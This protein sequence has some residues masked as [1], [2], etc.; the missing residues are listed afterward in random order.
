LVTDI[1]SSG[2]KTVAVKT[3]AAGTDLLLIVYNK[4]CW[5]ACRRYRYRCLE[6][7]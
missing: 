6:R 1:D 4:H 2:V 3:V 5:R 7:S